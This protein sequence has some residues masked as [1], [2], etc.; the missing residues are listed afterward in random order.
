MRP[1]ELVVDVGQNV[2]ARVKEV[3][4]L[5][6]A[7]HVGSCLAEEGEVW[8]RQIFGD[9]VRKYVAAPV[10]VAL[11][12]CTLVVVSRRKSASGELDGELLEDA[13]EGLQV[14]GLFPHASVL[15]HPAC[16]PSMLLRSRYEVLPKGNKTVY[17][18]VPKFA[19]CDEH[20]QFILPVAIRNT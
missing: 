12:L 13:R 15:S 8:S 14:T 3:H 11:K 1:L 9:A 19:V 17:E 20:P 4:K 2:D 10:A 16:T 5:A 18:T 7:V 6:V